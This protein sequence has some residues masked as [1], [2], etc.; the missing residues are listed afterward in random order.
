MEKIMVQ[1][2]TELRF[3]AVYAGN[4]YLFPADTGQK[5]AVRVRHLTTGEFYA[6]RLLKISEDPKTASYQRFL[7]RPMHQESFEWPVDAVEVPAEGNKAAVYLIYAIVKHPQLTSLSRLVVQPFNHDVLDWRRPFIRTLCFNLIRTLCELEDG[8]Y[9]HYNLGTERLYCDEATARVLV[10]FVPQIRIR[11]EEGFPD[12][13][14]RDEIAKAFAP[15]YL[16]NWDQDTVAVKPAD[17]YYEAAA[18]LFRL[19]MGKLPYDSTSLLSIGTALD[20]NRNDPL[21]EEGYFQSYHAF[22]HFVFDENDELAE[23]DFNDQKPYQRWTALPESIRAL[24]T[25]ALCYARAVGVGAG[26]I[27]S[28]RDWYAGLHVLFKDAGR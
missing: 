15:P 19:M 14:R 27:P 6:A 13:I 8:G 23:W 20:A 9:H 24:F 18:L 5:P 16:F 17:A 26:Q 2:G 28:L 21:I 12:R 25:R 4:M 11:G 3:S 1:E 22:P 7:L 10:C